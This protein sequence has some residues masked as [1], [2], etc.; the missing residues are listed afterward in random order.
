MI[1]MRILAFLIIL[2]ISKS[3]LAQEDTESEL[4]GKNVSE[5]QFYDIHGNT[6]TMNKF[7]G[8]YLYID[9]W[10]S[11]W[12]SLCECLSQIPSGKEPMEQMGIDEFVSFNISLDL[13]ENDWKKYVSQIASPNESLWIGTLKR[14]ASIEEANDFTEKWKMRTVPKYW[15][16]DPK[17]IIIKVGKS[18]I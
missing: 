10:H 12:A 5:L 9:F 15:I 7:N 2:F 14:F 18:G 11:H 6:I 3:L 17:G 8:N 4:I 1:I 13:R 16:V